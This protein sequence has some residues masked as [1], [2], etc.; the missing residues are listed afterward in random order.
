MLGGVL[1]DFGEDPERSGKPS[2]VHCPVAEH[3]AGD[4]RQD[5]R[6]PGRCD[7]LTLPAVSGVRPFVLFDGARVIALQ[8]KRL[9]KPFSPAA[10]LDLSEGTLEGMREPSRRRRRLV[11][12]S[13]LRSWTRSSNLMMAR[14]L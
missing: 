4:P 10:G 8:V 5:P 2:V 13:L 14:R 7:G 12:P 1:S 9:T 3:I 6:H 11:P